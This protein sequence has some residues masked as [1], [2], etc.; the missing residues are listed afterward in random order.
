MNAMPIDSTTSSLRNGSNEWLRNSAVFH[1]VLRE[2]EEELERMKSKNVPQGI[3]DKKDIQID[4]LVNFFNQ[5]DGLIQLYKIH[6]AN[7]RIENHFLTDLISKKLS[8]DDLMEYKPS[9]KVIISNIST[10]ESQT[11]SKLNG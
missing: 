7:L 2:L 4:A 5:T 9:A 6:M 10:S 3:I 8:I 11:L 1:N